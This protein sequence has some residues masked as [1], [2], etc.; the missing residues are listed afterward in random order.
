M[1]QSPHY[2]TQ[3]DCAASQIQLY[4]YTV[5][6]TSG[7]KSHHICHVSI[8]ALRQ[9]VE[10]EFAMVSLAS[11]ASLLAIAYRLSSKLAL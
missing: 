8:I 6:A 10:S 7:I 1:A 4:V 9:P 3:P 11:L 2:L 5:R